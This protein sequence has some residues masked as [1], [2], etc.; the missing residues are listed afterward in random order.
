MRKRRVYLGFR[1]PRCGGHHL[2]RNH[3]HLRAAYGEFVY[4]R[5]CSFFRQFRNVWRI[6]HAE[7]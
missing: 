1:C 5:D 3:A 6:D 4:C 7:H 2:A